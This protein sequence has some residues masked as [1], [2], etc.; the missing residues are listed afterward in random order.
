V[1]TL[2]SC[3]ATLSAG[4]SLSVTSMSAKF[5]LLLS[6]GDDEVAL[7]APGS[8]RSRS[9]TLFFT[10]DIVQTVKGEKVTSNDPN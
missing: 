5:I 7:G 3:I 4:T 10:P 2:F 8:L 6:P 9:D 1:S